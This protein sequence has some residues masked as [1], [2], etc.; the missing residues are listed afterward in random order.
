M[1]ATIMMDMYIDIIRIYIHIYIYI[2]LIYLEY[3][4]VLYGDTYW[5]ILEL[6]YRMVYQIV[7]SDVCMGYPL[8]I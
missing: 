1:T 7:G 3:H 4:G 2:S 5:N 8:V 6:L